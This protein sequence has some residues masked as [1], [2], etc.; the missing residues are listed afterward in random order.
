VDYPS[1]VR[2]PVR[3]RDHS[4]RLP[5]RHIIES[6]VVNVNSEDL[7]HPTARVLDRA[8]HFST[9]EEKLVEIVNKVATDAKRGNARVKPQYL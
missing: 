5:N 4:H 2:D 7:L 6:F 9:A 3:V 1:Q 8:S